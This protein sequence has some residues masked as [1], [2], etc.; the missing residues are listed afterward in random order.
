MALQYPWKLIQVY[1][2]PTFTGS[3]EPVPLNTWWENDTD[4]LT[5]LDNVFGLDGSHQNITFTSVGYDSGLVAGGGSVPSPEATWNAFPLVYTGIEKSGAS[6][7]CINWSYPTRIYQLLATTIVNSTPPSY[8]I[9]Y[10]NKDLQKAAAS[11][12]ST[13]GVPAAPYLA[14]GY[15][16]QRLPYA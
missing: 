2:Y 8:P 13:Y 9:T 16:V 6:D 4:V 5:T 12:V 7:Q 3:D 14:M 15:L 1:R 10:K 11:I